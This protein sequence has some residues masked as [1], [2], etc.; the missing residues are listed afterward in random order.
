MLSCKTLLIYNF[1][2]IPISWYQIKDLGPYRKS[3]MFNG[4][5]VVIQII[6]TCQLYY[7]MQN[8]INTN[9]ANKKSTE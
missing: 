8:S 5:D 7:S 9:E 2:F 6:S 3:R 1:I 4:T